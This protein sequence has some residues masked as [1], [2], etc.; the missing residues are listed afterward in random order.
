MT[1]SRKSRKRTRNRALLPASG[2]SFTPPASPNPLQLYGGGN[3]QLYA[4][5][6]LDL[7]A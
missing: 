4:G 6:T 1:A 2:T 5:G 3:L 7:Y